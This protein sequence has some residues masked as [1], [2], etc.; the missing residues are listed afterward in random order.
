MSAKTPPAGKLFPPVALAVCIALAVALRNFVFVAWYP[1]AASLLAGSAFALSLLP[2][3]GDTLA[4]SFDLALSGGIDPEGARAYCRKVTAAW[5]IV[6][7]ANAAVAAATVYAPRWVWF[8]WNC[9]LS[10]AALGLV[11]A[12]EMRIRRRTFAVR[13][14]TS[15][16][17]GSAKH[18]VKTFE[19]LA[20]EVAMHRS[21]LK[22]IL[23][24]KPVF[25]STVDPTH[26]YGT[27]WRRMLPEAAGC[28]ADP[29]VI[30][31]PEELI[32]K[33]SAAQSVFLVTTPSF[34][35]HLARYA[36]GYEIPRN[37][38]ALTTS[39]AL[40]EPR[41]AEA[42]KRIFGVVPLEIFGSTETGGVAWRRQDGGD[43][44]WRVF[45]PVKVG[46]SENGTLK[47]Q[48]PF[49]FKRGWYEMGDGV[50]LEPDGRA[51]KLLGRRDR[52]VKIAEERVD[53]AEMEA[54]ASGALGGVE[55]HLV[56]L[57]GETGPILG[58]VVEGESRPP[59][60]MRSALLKVFPKGTLPRRFRFVKEIARNEQGK[61]TDGYL[62]SLFERPSEPPSKPGKVEIPV[63]YE[64]GEPCFDGHFPG[65]PILP[66]VI[67]LGRAVDEARRAFAIASPLKTVKKMKF[68]SPIRPGMGV[69][70]ALERRGAGEV[71]YSFEADGCVHS[72]GTL[73]FS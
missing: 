51:F 47:V 43:G 34:I 44:L 46:I 39:G 18:I 30:G 67:Q 35:A 17:T 45:D 42:A 3:R 12:V 65:F 28:E 59:L 1:V 54:L 40:L 55:V 14:S 9:A 19:S 5:W 57:D 73:I 31:T 2:R 10:Y 62:R 7:W 11:W 24:K 66:G 36:D 8:T 61:V 25:L 52:M 20:K 56:K 22:D 15:G 72:C 16:S 33:M 6:L 50:E 26:M 64:A 49:S 48:S 23:A 21:R 38:V 53:L 29:S 68:M 69:T 32:A 63:R 58:A 41:V 13:F 71:S 27:L 37:V 60:E 4:H 70:L